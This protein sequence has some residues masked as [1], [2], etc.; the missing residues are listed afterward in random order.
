M[1]KRPKIL[2][3]Y[4]EL[5]GY[6]IAC[7]NALVLAGAE[8]HVVRKPVNSEAP[9][10]FGEGTGV[11]Y[12][13]RTQFSRK[14]LLELA[15]RIQPALIVVSGWV[16]KDYLYVTQK[17]RKQANTVLAFD[18]QWKGSLRQVLASWMARF[19]FIRSFDFAWVP[20]HRQERFAGKL[21]FDKDQ[22]RLGFYSSAADLYNSYYETTKT[23]KAAHFP[24][25]FVFVGRYYEFKGIRDLWAAFSALRPEEA[26]HW[27]LWCLGTGDIAPAEYPGI[28]HWGFVQPDQMEE[29]IRNSGIFILP[30]LF[31][32]W[33]VAVQEFAAAGFPLLCSSQVGAADVFLKDGINGYIYKAGDTEALKSKMLKFISMSDNELLEMGRQSHLLAGSISP[34]SWAAE[35]LSMVRKPVL[36][37]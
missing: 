19:S 23:A 16:D 8:V 34:D 36:P 26:R 13:E 25:R 15:S 27:E 14:A 2:F 5:A 32:P 21:G 35:A 30:S 7:L 31:E 33:G 12:Y 10:V 9:F 3:L 4:T 22:I 20:G 24:K 28:K 29:I 37:E 11:T 1:S 6:T 17:L 18:N